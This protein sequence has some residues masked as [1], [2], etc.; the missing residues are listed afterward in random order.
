MLINAIINGGWF[1]Q[2]QLAKKLFGEYSVWFW[3]YT[4][5]L[6]YLIA[7]YMGE[8]ATRYKGPVYRYVKVSFGDFIAF[9][10]AWV[11]L[12]SAIV[13]TS[14]LLSAV[15]ASLPLGKITALFILL[16]FVYLITKGVKESIYLSAAIGSI[17][18][19][20]VI[21]TI[22]L[23]WKFPLEIPPIP[24]IFTLLTGVFFVFEAFMGWET[25][26]NLAGKVKEDSIKFA[27][28]AATLV[29]GIFY[30][31]LALLHINSLTFYVPTPFILILLLGS[32]FDWL[33]STPNFIAQLAREKYLPKLFKKENDK[34]VP[35]YALFLFAFLST[36]IFLF[37]DIKAIL[38]ILIPS[39]YFLY[40]LIL[41]SAFY[42]LKQIPALFGAVMLL[43]LFW[44][45]L[46][47]H[48]SLQTFLMFF[49]SYLLLG[50]SIYVI[51]SLHKKKVVK[52]IHNL[53]AP[54][55]ALTAKYWKPL[56]IILTYLPKEAKKVLEIG[57]GTGYISVELAKRGFEVTATEIS[58][59]E[60]ELAKE[61][62]KKEGVLD[63]I[64]FILER[65]EGI[66]VKGSFDAAIGI[67][68]L[69]YIDNVRKFLRDLNSVVKP[70][71]T[72]IFVD[73]DYKKLPLVS[74]PKWLRESHKVKRLFR[75]FGFY[76][77]VYKREKLLWDEIIIVGR[78][79]KDV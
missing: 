24:P 71:G 47:F 68:V 45:N 52:V 20:T 37:A 67:G 36:I 32:V 65:G 79:F 3:I 50:T 21:I 76:V 73:Y 27:L 14:Y 22:L 19:L 35:L 23:N 53:F 40:A 70:G 54:I 51:Y 41:L 18:I 16:F 11:F 38:E 75:K 33:V 56:D 55:I 61:R 10:F 69:A 12:L 59:F 6:A 7:Y 25:V 58:E 60:L 1:I 77:D 46:L 66:S 34:G 17:A 15:S 57:C 43:F 64:V 63:K 72:I 31:I 26:A 39:S 8:L 2:Q 4:L 29:A 13:T 48:H 28:K 44:Y 30:I 5:P 74:A 62:A 42:K 78:K 9:L 49:I